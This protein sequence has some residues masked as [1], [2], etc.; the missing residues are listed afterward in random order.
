MIKA[1]A[2]VLALWVVQSQAGSL[3]LV[4]GQLTHAGDYSTR[5]MSATNNTGQ[6]LAYIKL[7]CGFF[8]DGKL[9]AVGMGFA[10]NVEK[11]QTAYVEVL[12]NH[13]P[14]A[15]RTDCRLADIKSAE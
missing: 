10:Q 7:E 13:A 2:I 9:L 3:D 12:A 14:G 4:T 6:Q 5:V 1:I 11:G 15:D 8:R